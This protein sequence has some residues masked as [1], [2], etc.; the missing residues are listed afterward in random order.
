MEYTLIKPVTKSNGEEVKTVEI[1]ESFTGRDVRTVCNSK[2]EGDA[3]VKLVVCATGFSETFVDNMDARDV[4]A[5]SKMVK[6][7]FAVGEN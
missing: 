3:Q 5:I 6:P 1:R 4:N 2:G 7:F